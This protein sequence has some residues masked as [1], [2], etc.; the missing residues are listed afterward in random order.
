MEIV[1]VEAIVLRT[2]TRDWRAADQ[3]H[4]AALVCITS[5]DGHVGIGEF[6]PVDHLVFVGHG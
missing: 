2:P 6:D 1:G 3:T 5:D 4:E